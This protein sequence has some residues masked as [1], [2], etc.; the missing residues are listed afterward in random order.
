MTK[1][2]LSRKRKQE[3]ELVRFQIDSRPI[4]RLWAWR[5]FA[6]LNLALP[7][8]GLS[9][10]LFRH[11][12]TQVLPFVPN[13]LRFA[14]FLVQAYGDHQGGVIPILALDG[15]FLLTDGSRIGVSDTF[16]DP[17]IV[18]STILVLC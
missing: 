9:S 1:Q 3:P 17:F 8:A 10:T 14:D 11:C 13:P 18:C 16:M 12:P 7:N 2:N 4:A 6:I 5:C 15:L